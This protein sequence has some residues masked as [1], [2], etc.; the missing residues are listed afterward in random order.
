MFVRISTHR[1][2]QRELLEAEMNLL[3]LQ[4][5]HNTLVSQHEL[6]GQMLSTNTRRMMVYME[7]AMKYEELL[8]RIRVLGGE[9]FLNGEVEHPYVRADHSESKLNKGKTEVKGFTDA[10]LKSLLQLVHPDKHG[11][12]ESAVRMTQL[13]NQLRG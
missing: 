11:G 7:A 10:E 6:Q 8:Q 12:K 5:Q 2:L 1:K 4:V 9:K 3:N 13:I